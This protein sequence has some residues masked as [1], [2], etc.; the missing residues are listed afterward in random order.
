[1]TRVMCVALALG[2]LGAGAAVAQTTPTTSVTQQPLA[3]QPGS[4]TTTP[5]ARAT[6]PPVSLKKPP[7]STSWP[8]QSATAPS[9]STAPPAVSTSNADS[10]TAAA[11]VSGANSF[12]E[13]EARSRLEAHGYSNVTGLT[14]DNQ[15]IW[16]GKA[17]KDGKSV[18]VALDYQGNIVAH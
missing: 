3:A 8:T 9:A 5:P 16:R 15:S 2:V 1:M 18:D 6:A 14:R 4:A 7:E 12:T 11:P 13:G 10:K 17:M